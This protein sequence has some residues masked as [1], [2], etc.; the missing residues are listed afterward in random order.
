MSRASSPYLLIVDDEPTLAGILMPVMK[1]AGYEVAVVDDGASAVSAAMA[2]T[3]DAIILDLGLPDLDGKEVIAR[4]RE[5]SDV[6]IIVVTARHQQAEK[7]E[8]LDGGA[9]DFISKPFDINELMAR[10]RAAL[11]RQNNLLRKATSF[12]SGALAIDFPT[13]QVT[14]DGEALRLSPKE[15]D[16]LKTLAQSE[17]RVVTHK[18]LLAVG[19]DPKLTETQY[20]RVYIALLRQKIEA[21]PSAPK[22]ILTEPGVGYRLALLDPH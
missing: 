1:A 21:E 3:P 6:P 10:V 5:W 12:Q 20:L 15:Y 19:W 16:L 4:I 2:R 18:Q 14:L 13:R 8:A 7:V 9:D 22:L 11:R 17:G